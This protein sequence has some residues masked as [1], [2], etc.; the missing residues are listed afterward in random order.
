MNILDWMCILMGAVGFAPW[1]VRPAST[2]FDQARSQPFNV[3]EHLTDF[4]LF[5]YRILN[6]AS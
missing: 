4:I 1:P 6:T 3:Y 5:C 2:Q